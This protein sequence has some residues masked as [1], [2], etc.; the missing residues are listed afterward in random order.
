MRSENVYRDNPSVEHPYSSWIYQ[1]KKHPGHFQPPT[2]V[3]SSIYTFTY[4]SINHIDIIKLP[5]LPVSVIQNPFHYRNAIITHTREWTIWMWKPH[6]KAPFFRQTTDY[7]LL[8]LYDS[9]RTAYLSLHTDTHKYPFKTDHHIFDSY[10]HTRKNTFPYLPS[11]SP[12]KLSTSPPPLDCSTN[13]KQI[14]IYVFGFIIFNCGPFSGIVYE[15]GGSA[16]SYI[17]N[18]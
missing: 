7:T 3:F 4:T 16:R 5:Y 10:E 2:S 17:I 8:R 6:Q 13:C 12:I 18:I 11:P 15:F 1:T 9:I 14:D